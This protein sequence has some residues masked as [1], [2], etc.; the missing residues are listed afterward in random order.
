MTRKRKR[1]YTEW[2]PINLILDGMWDEM[3]ENSRIT[4]I[5]DLMSRRPGDYGGWKLE[6]E[7]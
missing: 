3:P 7:Y 4:E 5:M 1:K 2:V 6:P